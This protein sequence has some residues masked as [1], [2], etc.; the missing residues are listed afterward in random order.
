MLILS[1]KIDEKI[2]IGDDIVITLID[3]HGDQVKIGVEAPKKVKVFR[4][5]VFDAIQK[6]NKEA[7]MENSESKE[8]I[9]AVSVLSKLRKK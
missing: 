6:E 9:D 3:V 1:R 8:A 7:A 5:E 4:Q 2:R